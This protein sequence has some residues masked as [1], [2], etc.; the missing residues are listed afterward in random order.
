MLHWHPPVN[1]YSDVIP[2]D[3]RDMVT[4]LAMFPTR[5][6][7]DIRKRHQT[8]YILLHRHFYDPTEWAAIEARFPRFQAFLEPLAWDNDD[9]L[10]EIVGWP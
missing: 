4:D 1:G 3:F 10:F 2:R 9:W 7:F 6:G 5:R 8:R